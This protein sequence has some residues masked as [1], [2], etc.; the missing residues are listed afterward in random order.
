MAHRFYEPGRFLFF[1]FFLWCV[2]LG[3]TG[4]L[5][6]E[7]AVR[8]E[9][10]VEAM[11]RVH[12]RFKG[13]PG[14]FAQF[15]DSITVSMAFWAPLADQP[16]GLSQDDSLTLNRVKKYMRSDCWRGWR[17][18][19]FGN[20]GGMTVR[21]A[22][23]NIDGWLKKLNPEVA[24]IMFG[25]NDIGQ[26]DATEYRQKMQQVVQRCLDNGTVVI[27]NTI[28]PRSGKLQESKELAEIVKALAKEA[29][30]P[31]V[32]YFDEVLKRRPTDWDGAAEKFKSIPG[33][34][35]E[36]PTLI[37]GD[38]VHPSAP[39]QFDHDFSQEALSA[40]GYALR[41]YLV[42]HAYGRVIERVLQPD[43]QPSQK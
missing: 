39:S 43:Q 32:N 35:Y 10:W 41:S 15:G 25:T 16:K 38:G 36:V 42:L 7:D 3:W 22:H 33:G 27:L 31:V 14:T 37:S 28:P 17:G 26:V 12:K 1:L 18:P 29:K 34:E 2:S 5:V 11:A 4:Q 40:N 30:V 8:D 13:E 20:Q 6:A 24:L 21:W 19:E 9:Y 23:E